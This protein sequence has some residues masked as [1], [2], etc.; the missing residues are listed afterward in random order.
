MANPCDFY[1]HGKKLK[2]DD[3]LKYVK[4]MNHSELNDVLCVIPSF[5]NIP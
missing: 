5:K 2:Y 3:F 1:I 4:K